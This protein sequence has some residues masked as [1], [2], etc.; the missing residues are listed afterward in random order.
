[1]AKD[2]KVIPSEQ[3]RVICQCRDLHQQIQHALDL[4]ATSQGLQELHIPKLK[5]LLAKLELRLADNSVAKLTANNSAAW[6]ADGAN[7]EQMTL[8]EKGKDVYDQL[9]KDLS[10][11]EPA[12][13]LAESLQASKQGAFEAFEG[14]ANY[15]KYTLEMAIRSGMRIHWAA[16]KNGRENLFTRAR[17]ARVSS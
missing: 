10:S 6:S 1:M 2:A 7:D 3:S 15:M 17:E 12:I 9:T 8:A 4:L 11:I 16:N 14:C 5:Q 13:D